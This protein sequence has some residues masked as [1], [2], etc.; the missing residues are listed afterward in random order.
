VPRGLEAEM[1]AVVE[2]VQVLRQ[3]ALQ[4]CRYC[5]ERNIPGHMSAEDVCQ[6]CAERHL[7]VAY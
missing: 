3:A 2:R 1:S 7:G 4:S 6:S 5:G